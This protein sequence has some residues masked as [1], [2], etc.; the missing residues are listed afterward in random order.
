MA[1]PSVNLQRDSE[2]YLSTVD[3]SGG[4]A[5]T[6]MTPANTWRIE[7]LAGYAFSQSAATQDITTLESGLNPDRSSKRFNSAIN[8]VEWNFQTYIRLTGIE[9][10]VPGTTGTTSGNSKPVADWMLW[11]CLLSNQ[12]PAVNTAE[13]SAWQNGGKFDTTER[14]AAANVAAHTPNYGIAQELH[15]YFKTGNVIS[16]VANAAV[17]QAEVS[18]AIDA[19]GMVTW[20]GNGTNLNE[21]VGSPRNA[22]VTVFGGILNNG[23]VVAPNSNALA[24][25]AAS[26][27]HPWNQYNVNGT[28]TSASFIK[29]RLSSI[30]LG[31]Q[32]PDGASNVYTFPVTALGITINNNITYLTPEELAALNT[33]IG[34]FAGARE[35]TGTLSAYLRSGDNQTAGFRRNIVNDPST[36]FAQ[37]A[38]AN[39]RIGGSVA[40]Y[41]SFWMPAVQ[42]EFPTTSIEDVLGLTINF[43][44]QEPTA[45]MGSGGEIVLFARK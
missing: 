42:F 26:S 27:Y 33:P 9:S 8:P 18:G 34:Q 24:L 14:V 12:A 40:P 28:V 43:K 4:A 45:S 30:T 39:V 15:L 44:A 16:Q 36:N 2:V 23:S 25:T 10:T 29:S 6:A 37:R 5:P 11:Q 19:I 38:N 22:A 35:I 1:L 13:R 3:L 31:Y 7:I 32:S 17:N 20:T 21:L 41:L